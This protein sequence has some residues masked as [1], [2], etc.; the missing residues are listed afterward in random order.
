MFLVFDLFVYFLLFF[1]VYRI[2]VGVYENRI[3]V[4]FIKKNFVFNVF[5]DN[6]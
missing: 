3:Y 4:Y 5:V 6:Y 2:I 1:C